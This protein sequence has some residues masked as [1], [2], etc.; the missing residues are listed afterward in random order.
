[1]VFTK[2]MIIENLKKKVY[3][4]LVTS[5]EKGLTSRTMTFGFS[6]NDKIFLL[7]HKGTPKLNDISF[8]KQ[9]LMHLGSIGDDVTQSFDISVTGTFEL[10][11]PDNDLYWMGLDLLGEK[12]PQVKDMLVSD[13]DARSHY[14]MILFHITNLSGWNY[15]Q[16]LSG[17][18]KTMLID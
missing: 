4:T 2:E 11:E 18:P 6:P 1:M 10:I 15:I 9:G 13:E 8:S 16:V 7:T 12:T 14:Q 17:M 3:A 5:G